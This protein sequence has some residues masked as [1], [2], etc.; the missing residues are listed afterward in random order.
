MALLVHTNILL[1]ACSTPSVRLHLPTRAKQPVPPFSCSMTSSSDP[2]PIL[3][4]SSSSSPL[5]QNH[6]Q[7]PLLE[8]PH[9]SP[10]HRH[11]MLE[12]ISAVDSGLGSQLLPSTLSHDVAFFHNPTSTSQGTL[13]IRSALPNHS[14]VDFILASW[15]HSTLPTG[16]SLDIA[17]I[18]AFLN[19]TTDAPHLS[20]EFIRSSPT[21]LVLLL[22]FLPR[23]DLVLYP[24]YLQAFYDNTHLDKQRQRLHKALGPKLRP[25][26]SSSLYIR[27][28]LSPT[29]IS[30]SIESEELDGMLA[31]EV[32]DVVKEV[33]GLWVKEC[34]CGG[35][36]FEDGGEMERDVLMRRDYLIKTKAI[37]VD[38]SAN[39]P[40]MFGAS[41][42]IATIFAFLNSTTDAPHLSLEF[43]RSSP[44]SL[45][46]L[47]DFL[48]RRDLVLYPDYL[49]AFY[50]N[51]HLDKQR[52]RLHK[53]LGPK[54]RPFVSSSLYI[55]SVLSPTA[56][57]VSI[58]SEELDG[59]LAGEV[60]DVVKEVVGL[61]VKECG[62]GGREFEGGGEM[63]R[64]VLMK[65]DYLIKT[66]TIEVDL[67][68]NLP[69]MFG[70]DVAGRVIE[71]IQ[72][73][74]GVAGL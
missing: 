7:R 55:R 63:E 3:P 21:S 5:L 61:W 14:K 52:Q 40:R 41:L 24:D 31:G 46:L 54:L 20:L 57:S 47:L 62:C 34:G 25:F 68:A 29:A 10:S 51:T 50:D 6:W 44:T 45:V 15:L 70:P 23:R 13:D 9:L 48:P 60:G 1:S 32:G 74:F 38:L 18:F 8:F 33:V 19:S 27:S 22:D 12:I 39:L 71:A 2:S 28:V 65:R 67:S 53:A 37:E 59:M 69:R 58:E 30:V 49:Q 35:R 42:D 43:I 72:K 16:A 73:A 56:I 17:T 64:D 26:V 66:K 4:S 11:L 36:E